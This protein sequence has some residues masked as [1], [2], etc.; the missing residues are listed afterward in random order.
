MGFPNADEAFRIQVLK[1][2]E[3]CSRKVEP[4]SASCLGLG[5]LGL[6]YFVGCPGLESFVHVGGRKAVRS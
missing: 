1:G 4:P 5:P 3:C 2:K 6:S